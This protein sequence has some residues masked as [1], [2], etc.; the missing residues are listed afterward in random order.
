MEVAVLATG[1][2]AAAAV[3]YAGAKKL[4]RSAQEQRDQDRVTER[5]DSIA[6]RS[7]AAGR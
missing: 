5:L 2:A 3:V 4:V 1:I 7:A 6:V